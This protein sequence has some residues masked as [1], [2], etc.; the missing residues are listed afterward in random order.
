MDNSQALMAGGGRLDSGMSVS[1]AIEQARGWWDK[2]GRHLM[3]RQQYEGGQTFAKSVFASP[4]PDESNF[5]PS[6]IVNGWEWDRLD[7]REKLRIVKYW[8]HF[9]VR[10]K[11]LIGNDGKTY[12]FGQRD[13][14]V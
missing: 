1:E 14:I 6:G 13:T 3:L 8:H 2:N 9:F 11:D 10:T 4:D 5:F 12:E 7:K